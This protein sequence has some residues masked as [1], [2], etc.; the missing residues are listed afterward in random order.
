MLFGLRGPSGLGPPVFPLE[1][2]IKRGARVGTIV[3]FRTQQLYCAASRVRMGHKPWK[4]WK[5]EQNVPSRTICGAS[6]CT[7]ATS[8]RSRSPQLGQQARSSRM[9]SSSSSPKLKV[10]S[11]HPHRHVL[12]IQHPSHFH[13]QPRTRT[14]LYPPLYNHSRKNGRYR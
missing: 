14:I 1:L 3:Q 13:H 9:R 4:E 2:Y 5:K 10:K 11:N 7:A 12:P 8:L 6:T